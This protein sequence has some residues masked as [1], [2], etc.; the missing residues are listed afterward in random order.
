VVLISKLILDFDFS[1]PRTWDCADVVVCLDATSLRKP[2]VPASCNPSSRITL[3][4]RRFS[5]F[6]TS[7]LI[8]KTGR[9]QS[10]ADPDEGRII[11]AIQEAFFGRLL[12]QILQNGGA[13]CGKSAIWHSQPRP[14][15]PLSLLPNPLGP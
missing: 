15:K 7:A 11:R 14:T 3:R 10:R 2:T 4:R 9:N 12:R 8:F 1:F 6:N 13:I 5:P